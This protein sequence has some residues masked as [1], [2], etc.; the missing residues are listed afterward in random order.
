MI[1]SPKNL[2]INH[3]TT[4]LLIGFVAILLAGIANQL[5]GL[6]PIDSISESYYR[7]G[8][9]RN[10]FVGLLFVIFAL[11]ITYN[12]RS[13]LEWCL[14][15]VAAIAAVGI[16][17][18]P[19]ACGAKASIISAIHGISAGIMFFI[20][21]IFCYLFIQRAKTKD[22]TQAKV[23]IIIYSI[24]CGAIILSII[25]IGLNFIVNGKIEQFIPRLVYKF[26]ALGLISFGLAWL[27]ASRMVPVITHK[28]ERIKISPF[29]D[30]E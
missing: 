16:A 7:D 9:A 18:Y 25:M 28:T 6:P 26:E 13:I 30:A 15:K 29:S 14:S 1:A 2:E 19:C 27:T 22:S 4:K 17:L 8:W 24:C 23:R 5:S 12:G 21:A 3:H 11:L 20:L 10:L